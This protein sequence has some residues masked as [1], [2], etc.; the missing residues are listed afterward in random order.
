[1]NWKLN[2]IELGKP[3]NKKKKCKK[4][5]TFF[6]YFD[7]FPNWTQ[8]DWV[9]NSLAVSEISRWHHRESCPDTILVRIK[10]Q[11]KTHSLIH[12][13]HFNI[14]KLFTFCQQNLRVVTVV[15]GCVTFLQSW[16]QT[17]LV[18][19]FLFQVTNEI[20]LMDRGSCHII[21]WSSWPCPDFYN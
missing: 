12:I 21:I 18:S 20:L 5:Y 13:L 10:K 6:F 8:S 17:E 4:S 3:S 15:S 2:L 9:S 16:S 14:S 19:L 11:N 1:M 7:G